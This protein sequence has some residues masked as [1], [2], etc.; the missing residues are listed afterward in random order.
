MCDTSS[1]REDELTERVSRLSESLLTNVSVDAGDTALLESDS[2]TEQLMAMLTRTEQPTVSLSDYLYRLASFLK[3]DDLI[4]AAIIKYK[5][6]LS[7]IRKVQLDE[8][9]VHRFVLAAVVVA[10]K[11]LLEKQFKF[12]YYARVGG[13]SVEELGRLELAFLQL[14]D[15]RVFS[16]YDS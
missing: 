15:W 3:F 11:C 2:Q 7:V 5:Q 12:S 4:D 14:L 9:N 10:S 1:S 8:H 16:W 13:V 6:R